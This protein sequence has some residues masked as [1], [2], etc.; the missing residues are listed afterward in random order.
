MADGDGR[1]QVGGSSVAS[2]TD[3][4]NAR[5]VGPGSDNSTPLC[6]FVV[7]HSVVLGA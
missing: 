4:D 6:R 5:A 7:E 2:P 3:P 1:R